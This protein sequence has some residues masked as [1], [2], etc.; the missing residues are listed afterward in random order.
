MKIPDEKSLQ[1]IALLRSNARMSVVELAKRLGVS[2]AT[3]QNKI[4]RLEQDGSIMGYTIS[5]KPEI[6]EHPVRLLINICV[7]AKKESTLISKLR[8]YPQIT[9][10]HHTIGHWDLIAQVN[11]PDLPSLSTLLSEIVLIEG[12]LK[13][14]THLLTKSYY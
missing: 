13:T 8:G 6:D 10:V 7:E 4:N 3:V 11:A 14:E 2:R 5:L 1:L 9:Q 12:I